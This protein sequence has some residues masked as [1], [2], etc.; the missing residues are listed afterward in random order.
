MATGLGRG[1][2]G[3]ERKS[4]EDEKSLVEHKSL[5]KLSQMLQLPV[6]EIGSPARHLKI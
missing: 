3:R 4:G 2:D 1:R 6:H 5:L